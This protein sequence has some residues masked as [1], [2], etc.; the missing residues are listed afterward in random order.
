MLFLLSS[1]ALTLQHLDDLADVGGEGSHQRGKS[2]HQDFCLG[3]LQC[4]CQGQ[5]EAVAVV[6]DTRCHLMPHLRPFLTSRAR[7]GTADATFGLCFHNF[8][9]LCLG[10]TIPQP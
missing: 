6:R 4:R 3:C 1:G 8:Q 5:Q 7:C 2:A 10:L 9:R